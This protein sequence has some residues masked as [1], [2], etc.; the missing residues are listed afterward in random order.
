MWA[1]HADA[2]ETKVQERPVTVPGARREAWVEH[3]LRAADYDANTR[4]RATSERR[5]S[6]KTAAPTATLNVTYNGFPA[7]ARAAFQF[8]A[9][10][11]E[12]HIKSSVPIDI[13]ATWRALDEGVLGSAGARFVDAN[14]PHLPQQNTWYAIALS[15]ALAGRNLS[16]TDSDIQASFSSAFPNWYFGTDGNTPVGQYDLATV[17]LHEIG[18]GLGFFDGF[19][20]DD[21]DAS[22]GD[23]CVGDVGTGCGGI[24]A[25]NGQTFPVIF[26]RFLEDAQGTPTLTL[27]SPSLVLGAALQSRLLFDGETVRLTT[28]D[29]PVDL[30]APVNFE[31]G[32]STA[33]LDEATFPAGD[34]NSLMTPQ[35]GRAESIFSPGAITCAIFRDIGWQLGDDCELLLGADILEFSASIAS[36]TDNA[37]LTFRTGPTTDATRVEIVQ[38]YFD[39]PTEVVRQ[40]D[41]QPGETFEVMLNDLAPGRYVFQLRVIRESGTVVFGPEQSLT[42]ALRESLAFRRLSANPFRDEAR[43]SLQ[44][45]RRQDVDVRLYTATGQ[46]VALV[47]DDELG[48]GERQILRVAGSGLAS[49]VYFLVL[50]GEA[51]AETH[52]LVHLQ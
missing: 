46:L 51:F 21:G 7:E 4:V 43:F 15:E 20:Y 52:Q 2:C 3:T 40:V 1:L 34:P 42:V 50:R 44:V 45:K 25:S 6:G 23:E 9:D 26:D 16:G 47:F 49:G 36:G 30:Y 19:N 27:P 38:R 13:E 35:L 48:P 5:G 11:W 17:V 8:A 28:G 18:H 10:I 29:I 37:T 41:V 39:D 31:P 12:T 32:S 22:N 14:E 24:R 33:H